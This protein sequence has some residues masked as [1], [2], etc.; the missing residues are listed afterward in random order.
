MNVTDKS[1]ADMIYTEADMNHDQ[2]VD[3]KE[4]ILMITCLYLMTDIKSSDESHSIA[5]AINKVLEAFMFFDSDGDGYIEKSE[6]T[7]V[8]RAVCRFEH[9][10]LTPALKAPRLCLFQLFEITC[11]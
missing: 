7:K 3:F 8:R 10:S 1:V 5:T 11:L 9:I 2:Q 4:Y 6:V